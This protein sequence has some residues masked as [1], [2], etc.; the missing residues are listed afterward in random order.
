MAKK[1]VEL[2]DFCKECQRRHIENKGYKVD[3]DG[4]EI[5]K[6]PIKCIG[7][8]KKHFEGCYFD[9]ESGEIKTGIVD[10]EALVE[11]DVYA[12]LTPIEKARLQYFHNPLLWAKDMLGWTPYN[13]NRASYQEY[14]KE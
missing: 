12:K 5:R 8:Q 9:E 13:P 11:D 3:K 14:Q 4:N 10:L 2:A 7:I 6:W 1:K